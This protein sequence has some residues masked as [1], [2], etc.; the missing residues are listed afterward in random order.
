MGRLTGTN[1]DTNRTTLEGY[2]NDKLSRAYNDGLKSIN[3][4]VTNLVFDDRAPKPNAH[5]YS[6]TLVEYNQ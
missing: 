3:V 2:D 5:D 4:I 1:A 6:M